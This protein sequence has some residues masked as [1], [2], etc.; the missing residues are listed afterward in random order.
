[1]KKHISE[2][3]NEVVGTWFDS[4]TIWFKGGDKVH[5]TFETTS[6][7][8]DKK[9]NNCIHITDYQ[10]GLFTFAENEPTVKHYYG[11]TSLYDE[12]EYYE[13]FGEDNPL[14]N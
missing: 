7:E 14:L 12:V 9:G 13:L 3:K 6:I 2:L 8:K 4:V 5:Y 10:R 1:M 11:S